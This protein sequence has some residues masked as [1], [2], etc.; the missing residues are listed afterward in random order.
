MTSVTAEAGAASKDP[1]TVSVV[2]N[3]QTIE[4]PKGE[5]TG[6]QIKAFA[7]AAGIAIQPNFPLA[8]KHGNR[9]ENVGDT[10]VVKVHANQE[11]TSVAGDDNS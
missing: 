4:I 10:D 3:N 6:A 9:F 1:K 8:V 7:I 5:H 2:F 11:F